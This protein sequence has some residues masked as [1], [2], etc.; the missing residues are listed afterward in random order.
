[1][2]RSGR[3]VHTVNLMTDA[4]GD[5]EKQTPRLNGNWFLWMVVESTNLAVGAKL[6]LKDTATG[7]VLCTL[8]NPVAGNVY[9]VMQ[10]GVGKTAA[11]SSEY[12]DWRTYGTLT[13][14]VDS[15][16]SGRTAKVH[17]AHQNEQ[18]HNPQ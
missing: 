8:T 4:S 2:A 15:G 13:L 11:S 10:Q 6:K 5:D 14:E 3:F 7:R 16:T 1:M 12:D 9:P 17:V 18:P